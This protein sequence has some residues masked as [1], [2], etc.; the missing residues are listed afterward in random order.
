MAYPRDISLS[1]EH[2]THPATLFAVIGTATQAAIPA[3]YVLSPALCGA[4][5]RICRLNPWIP[6][7]SLGDDDLLAP[8]P[9]G[10]DW[11]IVT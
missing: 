4:R 9:N 7:Y 1:G 5:R 10:G 2:E 3:V 11:P 6:D 8:P